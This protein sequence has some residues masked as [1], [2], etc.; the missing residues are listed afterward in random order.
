M[1]KKVVYR[2]K[3]NGEREYKWFKI[4]GHRNGSGLHIDK[5]T[6]KEAIEFMRESHVDYLGSFYYDKKGDE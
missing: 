2:N 6:E 3:N 5:S 1:Y 4:K